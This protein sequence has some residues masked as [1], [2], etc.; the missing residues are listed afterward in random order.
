MVANTAIGIL[1]HAITSSG[2]GAIEGITVTSPRFAVG[3]TDSRNSV[4][5]QEGELFEVV[6]GRKETWSD[7]VETRIGKPRQGC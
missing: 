2:L 4:D 7:V 1:L 6:E 5:I 3:L